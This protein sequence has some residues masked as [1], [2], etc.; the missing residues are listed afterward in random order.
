V[1]LQDRSHLS[2]SEF[3]CGTSILRVITAESPMPL[4][5]T[6]TRSLLQGLKVRFSYPFANPL[7]CDIQE[8]EVISR[9][10]SNTRKS[11]D[12][13]NH[14]ESLKLDTLNLLE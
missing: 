13:G 11:Q 12:P 6:D 14:E 3:G 2:S 10:M 7:R 5:P 9:K 4:F 8:F 1:T